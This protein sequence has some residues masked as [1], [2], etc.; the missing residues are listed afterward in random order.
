M[1]INIGGFQKFSLSDYPGKVAAIIFLRGC[2]FRCQYCHNPDLFDT[3]KPSIP[4]KNIFQFLKARKNRLDGVVITGG[5]PT[6]QSDLPNFFQKIKNLGF[7]I[8]LNTNGSYPHQLKTLI[9]AKLL[10]YIAMDIKAPLNK[11]HIICQKKVDISSIQNSIALI[12]DSGLSH[13]FRTTIDPRLISSEDIQIIKNTL[14]PGSS[15]YYTPY[16]TL[17]NN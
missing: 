17:T 16:A 2:N 6:I 8:K 12:I 10:D 9:Q 3:N 15:L 7:S 5:E 11:Y 4:L 13:E 1:K 14:L